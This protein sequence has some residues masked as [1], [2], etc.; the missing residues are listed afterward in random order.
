[1]SICKR[2]EIMDTVKMIAPGTPIREG[3]EHILRARTGAL[4][5]IGNSNAVM[6]LV[7][8]GFNI[9]TELGPSHLYELAKMDGAIIISKDLNR[10]L[11]ANALLVPDTSIKT[12][13]TGTR[14]KSAERVAKQTGEVVVCIS[15]RRNIITLFKGHLKYILR[16]TST[17]TSK[18]N[19]AIQTLKR[20][21]SVLDDSYSNLNYLE[22]ENI[23]AINDVVSVVQ[24]TEMAMLVV[25]EIEAFI[26][27]LGQEGR[28]I[29][30]QLEELVANIE[31]N[32]MLIIQ[33][34]GKLE[35]E[36]G[37]YIDKLRKLSYEEIM[38]ESNIIRIM[39]YQDNRSDYENYLSSRGY[40]ILSMI[41]KL[42]SAVIRKIVYKF[43]SLQT[44]LDASTDEL[45]SVEGVGEIRAK[46]ISD[47]LRRIRE[48]AMLDRR[49]I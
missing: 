43:S 2:D 13:E 34:Y 25:E 3:L 14:H 32:E 41:H 16:D 33:D 36:P 26:C 7:D 18:A 10:I 23:A 27:E 31:D 6:D 22:F 15:S 49:K 28:L 4:I 30:M 12:D 45:E 46:S 8:G 48:L 35:V 42:P 17:V 19:Q 37:E 9:D 40:R 29:D 21:R 20:Y 47:G 11:Y 39:G 1:M 38:E 44:V 5:L 24:K